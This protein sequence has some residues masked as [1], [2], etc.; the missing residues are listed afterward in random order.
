[1]TPKK[2][3]KNQKYENTKKANG[4]LK[5]T[6]WCPA[7]ATEDLKE[8]MA[9]ICELYLTNSEHGNRNLIPAMYRDIKTGR[10]GNKSLADI[11]KKV[12]NV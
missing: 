7:H 6:T 11:I 2:L 10:N 12:G 3:T 5:V 9:N 4:L 1:M 8:L